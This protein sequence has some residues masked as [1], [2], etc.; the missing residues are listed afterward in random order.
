MVNSRIAIGGMCLV[1]IVALTATDVS[2]ADA[3]SIPKGK[4]HYGWRNERAARDMRHA[5]DYSRDLYLYSRNTETVDPEI[6]KSE[7]KTLGQNIAA[8][9]KEIAGVRKEAGDNKETLQAVESIEKHLGNAAAMHKTLHE[10]CN[11]TSVDG[12]ASAHCC[13]VITKELEKAMAEHSAL[14]RSI[15]HKEKPAATN[16]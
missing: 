4:P 9:Q 12:K 1:M 6:A 11:M 15:D 3:Q 13:S 2:T 10:A 14:I 7:S 5:R 16:K 8:A